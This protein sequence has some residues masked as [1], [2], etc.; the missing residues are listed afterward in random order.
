MSRTLVYFGHVPAQGA[1][2]GIIVYRHL[3]RFQE[4]GWTVRVVA[5]WG[6]STECCDQHGW[7]VMTLSHRKPHWPPFQPDNRLSRR[8]RTWLWAGEVRSWL[9]TAK[10]DAVCTYLSAFSDTLSLAAVGFARRYGLP[11]ATI[12]HDDTRCF[13]KNEDEGRRG[14]ARRQWILERSTKGWFASPALARTF[15]LKDS[16]VGLLPPIPE[17]GG[18]PARVRERREDTPLLVYAGS[19]WAQQIPLLCDLAPVVK[20]GGGSLLAVMK[21]ESGV[22][23][24]LQAG[25]VAWRAPFPKNT[26]A[27]AFFREHAAAMVVS[28][29]RE[30]GEMPWARTSFPSKLI[31]Y[32]HLGLP[33]MIVAQEDTAVVQ[34]ARARR[35]PDVFLP[36]DTDGIR[37]FVERLKDP[38][39]RESRAELALGFA[40]GEFDPVR[41]QNELEQSLGGT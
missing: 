20:A 32:C 25:G 5:D 41:I 4:N 10:P 39:F 3:R 17:G 31:E 12:V 16:I 21:N 15:R 40:R 22:A 14:H 29:S 28:Y 37:T 18:I 6:Q 33:L 1:G 38:A 23:D 13:A 35:F 27:L 24:T 19:H 36:G 2:S 26:D 9:G 11:L 7:P 34:W 8:L 30:S